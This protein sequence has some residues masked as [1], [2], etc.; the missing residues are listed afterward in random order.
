MTPPP[1]N[2]ERQGYVCL[3]VGDH[4]CELRA[5]RVVAFIEKRCVHTEGRYI[6]KP[7]ILDPWQ[8]DDI[9]RPIF[10]T[11]RWSEEY[12]E[13]VRQYRFA[14]IEIGR[15]NGKS[16]LLAACMLYLLGFD[17]EWSAQ[18]FGIAKDKKQASL[19]FNVAKKM[20]KYSTQLSKVFR[21]VSNQKKIIH[22]DTDS[23]Y[24]VI[25]S[26]GEAALGSNPSGVAGDEI[27]AWKSREIWDAMETGMGSGAR[28][29]PLMLAATTAGKDGNSFG[30]H[31]HDEMELILN[32]PERAPDTFVYIRNTPRDADLT[33]EASWYYANPALGSFLSL[34]AFRA[35]ALKA[36]N[37]PE[38]EN[39]FRQFRLNQW[40][41]Q[42]FRWVNMPQWDALPG[43]PWP[44][45]DWHR[46]QLIGR[47]CYAGMDLSGRTDLTAWALVFEPDEDDEE[48]TQVLWRFWAT[49]R[50]AAE[51]D[52]VTD[53]KFSQWA[54]DGWVEIHEGS[55]INY[56]AV[57]EDIT[58]DGEDFVIRGLH[59]D[60]FSMQ[61]MINKVSL[62]CG[63]DVEEEVS[64]YANSYTRM[65][66]ALGHVKA[67]MMR[68][69]LNHHGNP[70]ARWNFES[71]EVKTSTADPNLITLAKPKRAPGNHRIDGVAAA[72]MAMSCWQLMR[73]EEDYESAYSD[74]NG[75]MVV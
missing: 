61:P 30:K 66:P 20:I 19:V 28:R 24:E 60:I 68:S 70:V 42:S 58:R 31:M 2:Y 18:L 51:L 64:A 57:V 45:P 11:M 7:F 63:L 72:A 23:T 54:R 48:L 3:E 29:S 56:D 52:K 41:S 22:D 49:E 12:G 26:D 59:A 53:G 1:C 13:Y 4:Y 33:D 40:V 73:D 65:S 34:E 8:K 38:Q 46:D 21:V 14:W 39:G 43:E 16:E 67:E 55:V 50:A 17:D 74:G 69:R 37:D 75:L 10:G 25:A 9:V 15:K 62:A 32:D 6:R 44:S 47:T 71:V 27:L 35:A 36:L 5:D